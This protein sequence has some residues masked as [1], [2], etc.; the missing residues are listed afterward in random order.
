MT[1]LKAV[2][3]VVGAWLA[4]GFAAANPLP[5]NNDPNNQ[6]RFS[7]AGAANA[8][9]QQLTNFIWATGLPVSA[10]P[11]ITANVGASIFG[12]DLSGIN[13]S[14]VS[15][16][17]RLDADVSGYDFHSISYLLTPTNAAHATRVV[18]VH[19]GHSSSNT[20]LDNGVGNTVNALLLQG[21]SVNVMQMPLFGWNN[22]TTALVPGQ[23]VL[24]Y[25]TSFDG[26]AAIINST[27]PAL[28]GTGFRL[29][30]E[31]VIQ[32]INY[33]ASLSGLVD[34]SMI[35]ISGGGWTTNMVAAID[36]RVGLSI[37]V[38]GSAPLFSRNND[39]PSVG[40]LEQYYQPLYGENIAQDGS[41]GGVATWMEI[42]ALGGYGAA[43]KQVMVTNEFDPCCFSGLF[44]DPFKDIVS[45]A[46][47]LLNAGNWDYYLDSTSQLHEITGNTMSRV[48]FPA[49]GV[50]R[51][52]DG[53][54]PPVNVNRVAEPSTMALIVLGLALAMLS[55]LRLSTRSTPREGI[56]AATSPP[57]RFRPQLTQCPATGG[58][59]SLR[60][61]SRTMQG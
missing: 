3:L 39:P 13:P 5:T 14:L 49:L 53:L 42:Y 24:N 17:T 28:G 58:A 29:F 1:D 6:I 4:A 47:D 30:L 34:V 21:F 61:I 55:G 22:D 57:P 27:G 36:T 54:D 44:A 11:T 9:R 45:N 38:A 40:D 23:G 48:L 16:V 60:T 31:P 56:S 33:F 41:G 26:H 46:V 19:Q 37:P 25:G 18:I 51:F 8:K 50:V 52:I 12:A 59:Q 2:V 20:P 35:G 15:Q 7:T 10:M 32:S 43:R